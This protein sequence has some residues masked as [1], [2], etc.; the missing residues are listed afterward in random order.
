ML[1]SLKLYVEPVI[2][3]MMQGAQERVIVGI[4]E[5]KIIDLPVPRPRDFNIHRVKQTVMKLSKTADCE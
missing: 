1:S 3:Q 4:E 2:G 5:I